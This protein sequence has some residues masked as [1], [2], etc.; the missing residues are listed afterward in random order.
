MSA[1]TQAHIFEPFFTTKESGKGTGLGL[2]T[3]YGTVRQAGGAIL[4]ESELGRGACFQVYFPRMEGAPSRPSRVVPAGPTRGTETILVVEDEDGIRSLIAE[5]LQR[6]G[7]TVLEASQGREALALVESRQGSIDL[8]VTDLVMPQMGGRE[9]AEAIVA[10]HP[11]IKVLY[12]SGYPDK[13]SAQGKAYPP[14]SALM[15]KPFAPEALARKVRKMLD[16]P[17]RRLR[18]QNA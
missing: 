3:V 9:L 7:Y 12:I 1:E 17:P 18:S 16:A 4:V 14:G 13:A 5:V 6:N 11:A 15:E 8:L 10:S 2:S